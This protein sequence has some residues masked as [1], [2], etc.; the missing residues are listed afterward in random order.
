M[1]DPGLAAIINAMG[2]APT[3]WTGEVVE[4]VDA[5]HVKVAIGSK[6]RTCLVSGA[7]AWVC[8]GQ[9]VI[10]MYDGNL[11]IV[12]GIAGAISAPKAL[13]HWSGTQSCA[14]SATTT[15]KVSEASLGY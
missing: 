11:A 9:D 1:S 5:S 3:R 12:D 13:V 8:P 6:V 10:V 14:D 4:L 2:E 7:Y 15:L